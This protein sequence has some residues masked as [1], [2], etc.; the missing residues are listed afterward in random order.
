MAFFKKYNGTTNARLVRMERA[1]WALIYGGL[2]TAILG[3]FTEHTQQK[4]G[5]ALYL[6]GAGAVAIG[7]VMIYIRSRLRE[8][9]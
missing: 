1:I 7:V 6:A 5:T 8:E 3:Y 4:D 2:L 9:N